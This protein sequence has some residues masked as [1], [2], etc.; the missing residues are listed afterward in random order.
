MRRAA[1]GVALVG[2]IA[3]GWIACAPGASPPRPDVILIV[4]DTTRADRCSFLG[5][6]RPTTPRLEEFAKDAVVFTEAWSP[7]GWTGPAHASLFTGLRAE[8]HG[9]YTGNSLSLRTD[10]PTLAEILRAEG[11]ATGCFT[12]N[13]MIGPNSGMHRAF[14]RFEP[15][16]EDDTR[17]YPWAVATHQ[18]ASGWAAEQSKA[19][20]PFFLF[21]ND[22]E[23]HLK[24]TPTHEH[25]ATFLRGEHAPAAIAEM[26]AWD[27]PHTIAYSAGAED[28]T[29]AQLGVLSDLYDA[30]IA[31]LDREIGALL[32]RLRA[33]GLLDSAVVVI[34]GDHGELLGEHHMAAHG[35]SMH[36]A[37]RHIPLLVRAPERFVGGRREDALVRL[38][39]VFPTIL[40]LCG[41]A[42]PAGIDGVTLTRDLEGRVSRAMQGPDEEMKARLESMVPGANASR[43]TAGIEAVFD[44]RWHLIA[45]GDGRREL[46]D[47]DADPG[48][49]KDLAGT[50]PDEVKRLTA[51]LRE[52][53]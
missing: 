49:T 33:L 4:M 53:P 38:E 40:E 19:R 2:L 13:A 28:L 32:D 22:M 29:P 7:A 47:L 45:Y 23:P 9:F 30:E 17:P 6:G 41:V 15:F 1:A 44:G 31:T 21:I 43:L 48:E 42:A 25:E 46:Y 10:V 3:G 16:Y 5:Y 8:R 50:H 18:V 24:Y 51:L 52:R 37:A 14:E 20:K 12:N 39:D 11:Y 36:R 34:L 35:F 26:R 27:F